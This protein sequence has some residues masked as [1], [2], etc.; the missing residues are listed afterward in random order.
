MAAVTVAVPCEHDTLVLVMAKPEMAAPGVPPFT[1]TVSPGYQ[2]DP[3]ATNAPPDET[4][5]EVVL[6]VRVP[7]N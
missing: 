6:M 3:V 4:M 7:N 5:V 1:L 2:L